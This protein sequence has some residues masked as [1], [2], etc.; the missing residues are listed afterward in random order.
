M[1]GKVP[2]ARKTGRKLT[3]TVMPT[4]ND[5]NS[6]STFVDNV[7]TLI[8]SRRAFTDGKPQDYGFACVKVDGK[9]ISGICDL[10]F[11]GTQRGAEVVATFDSNSKNW[12]VW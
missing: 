1:S 12:R 8:S 10:D 2:T 5:S 7:G 3:K 9:L 11:I 4:K 6:K